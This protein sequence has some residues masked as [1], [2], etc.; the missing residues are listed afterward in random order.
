MLMSIPRRSRFDDS[1]S[2]GHG[3]LSRRP[4]AQAL[5]NI[6]DALPEALAAHRQYERLM[7]AGV[8]HDIALKEAMG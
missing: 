2:R 6:R 1:W 4:I 7:S 5:R 3:H 8:P